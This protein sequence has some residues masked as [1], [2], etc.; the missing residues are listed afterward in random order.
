ME[1]SGPVRTGEHVV[2][3]RLTLDDGANISL[4]LEAFEVFAAGATIIDYTDKGARLLAPPADRYF[5]GNVVGDLDSLVVLASGP[6]VRGFIFTA[7]KL[8]AIAPEQNVYTAGESALAAR[9]RQ[10]DPVR[11]RPAGMQP[12]RC[13]VEALPEKP[14]ESPRAAALG[15][16]IAVEPLFTNTVYTIKLA[17]ETDYEF[18]QL[19]NSSD[20][21]LRF[22]G[23]LTAAAS[24]IYLRD[25][26]TVFQI[27]TVHL[28]ST[29]TNPWSGSYS[30]TDTLLYA[31]GDYWHANYSSV[32]RTT[33]HML[34]GKNLGGGIAWLGVLCSGDFTCTEPPNSPGSCGAFKNH[35][36][37]GYGLSSSLSAQFST[38]SP[39]LYWDILSYTHE[40][41]H[42]FNS[43]HT[44]CYTP[45]VDTCTPCNTFSCTGSVP[46]GGGT[47]MSYCHACSGGYNNII[48][49]FGQPGQ[50]SSAVT[51]LMRTYVESNASCLLAYGAAPTVTG[52]NP[53]SGSISGGTPVTIS[54]TGFQ[55]Y[56]TVTIGGV[57]ATGVTVVNATTITATTGAHAAGTVGVVVQN[58]DA[59][60]ATGANAY[61]YGA[62]PA[63]S[64]SSI[65]PNFGPTAGGALV[66][67]SGAN[68]VSGA[69]VTLGGSAAAVG[70]LSATTI[71][72]TTGSHAAGL[73]DVVV[74][75]PDSQAATLSNGYTYR[76]PPIAT[77]FFAVTP[78]RL[79]DTRHGPRDVKEP[80]NITPAGFQRGSYSDGAIRSYDLTLSTDCPGLPTGVKAWSLLFQ[81]TTAT[82]AS[83]LQAW[84]YVSASGIG[85]QAPPNSESTML[86]YTD[87]WTANSAIIPGG[88]DANGSINVL[89]QHA[90]DVI[91]EVNGYF[92]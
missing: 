62:L 78:C 14:A 5:R 42:N 2:I 90:G 26:K 23:D 75:N 88:D 3:P 67:I 84:P 48:L 49:Y 43:P 24:A 29:S 46:A 37:G 53:P 82:Q 87:R 20:G 15:A 57:N 33:V 44:E 64:V 22:I 39:G 89:A 52:V 41:G 45:A 60:S 10:I 38:T 35:W 13:G 34:S 28:Y 51:D 61:T 11:D 83:Y 92:K 12:F 16:P 25:V 63:P 56:A 69:S 65:Y 9:V 30:G 55:S 21:A 31:L 50:P 7:G 59:Q 71:T 73:V 40:I 19:F 66:T 76:A 77:K 70:S 91:V 81:F 4:D 85:S 72:A 47:I 54:G 27:S 80:G 1:L 32:P 79:V 17:L 58:P 68:F 74:K 6:T 18:Y 8:Y 86:G 36:G